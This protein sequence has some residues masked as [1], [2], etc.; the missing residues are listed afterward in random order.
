VTN[1][2]GV[3]RVGISTC[4]NDTFAFHA[5]LR[6]E[7]R[8]E[9]FE[10]EFELHDVQTLNERFRAGELDAAK[11][12]FAALLDLPQQAWVLPSGAALGIGV[13]PVVLRS[14][15]RDAAPQVLAPGEHTTANLLWRLFH[16]R[17]AAPRQV[18]F[19][20]IM[21][22]LARGEARLG[23]C[24]HE[25][26]FTYREHGL[27]LD[28]DLGARWEQ[29]TGAPLPLGGI[30]VRRRRGARAARALAEAIGRSLDWSRARPQEALASMRLHAQEHSD[31]VLWKHVEL[32]VTDQTR[33]LDASGRG[34]LRELEQRASAAGLAAP[35]GGALDVLE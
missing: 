23:V 3:L 11:V 27:E 28:E 16:P 35:G 7:V 34:A 8:V 17:E 19:S 10:V 9:G 21:P 15:R 5:L 29:A 6:G 24:I 18:V 1:A 31:A 26:R 25:G 33:A 22:A 32:Y 13:G 20:Q 14:P 12:S 30:A 4:P 2:E